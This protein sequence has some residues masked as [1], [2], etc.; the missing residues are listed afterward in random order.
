MANPFTTPDL[1]P[2]RQIRLP[3]SASSLPSPAL[4]PRAEISLPPLATLDGNARKS[5]L[6]P[7]TQPG[8]AST[9]AR[10][11]EDRWAELNDDIYHAVAEHIPT[12][13]LPSLC[14]TSRRWREMVES[15]WPALCERRFPSL[16]PPLTVPPAVLWPVATRGEED[17]LIA[18]F[19]SAVADLHADWPSALTLTCDEDGINNRLVGLMLRARTLRLPADAALFYL[20]GLRLDGASPV[21]M[22]SGD[23]G[24]AEGQPYS[25]DTPREPWRLSMG[26]EPLTSGEAEDHVTDEQVA[27]APPADATQAHTAP[28]EQASDAAVRAAGSGAAAAPAAS[29]SLIELQSLAELGSFWEVC[30]AA[31]WHRTSTTTPTAALTSAAVGC[32]GRCKMSTMTLSTTS[33]GTA[34]LYYRWPTLPRTPWLAHARC[35]SSIA[36]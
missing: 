27:G 33:A 18:Q 11:R 25:E 1:Q 19:L 12:H 22:A 15:A 21:G 6:T 34:R 26:W 31:T 24:P 16:P 2:Q 36:T 5:S 7:H 30:A 29:A 8:C 4:K 13:H 10:T 9:L 28:S 17:A 20:L 3:P 14:C 23:F 35:S 32:A